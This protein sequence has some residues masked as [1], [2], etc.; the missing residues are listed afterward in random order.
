MLEGPMDMRPASRRRLPL[1]VKPDQTAEQQTREVLARFLR[2]A[3]RRMPISEEIDR[4]AGLLRVRCKYS[5]MG[6]SHAPLRKRPCARR[7]LFLSNW[8]IELN[9]K[10]QA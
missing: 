1:A 10:M 2:Q 5:E 4:H 6:S 8:T 9:R 7:F 3:F